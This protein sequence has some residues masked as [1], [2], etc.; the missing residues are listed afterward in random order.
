MDLTPEEKAER[1]LIVQ[2]AANEFGNRFEEDERRGVRDINTGRFVKHDGS[3]GLRVQIGPTTVPQTSGYV[4]SQYESAGALTNN[5]SAGFDQSAIGAA[6]TYSGRLTL[7]LVN[8]AGNVW[9]CD[10]VFGS[11]ATT[12]RILA[13]T[14]SLAGTLGVVRITTTNGTDT[15]DAGSVNILYE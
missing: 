2:I 7:C 9:V 13:G 6:N 4:G 10:S 11:S 15:F 12:T 1:D 8:A 14:K 3:A 5:F